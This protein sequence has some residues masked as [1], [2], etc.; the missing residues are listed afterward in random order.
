MASNEGEGAPDAQEGLMFHQ[1]MK[2]SFDP[3]A[4]P[5]AGQPDFTS[6]PNRPGL[7]SIELPEARHVHPLHGRA[8]LVRSLVSS[9]VRR[10][11]DA[12]GE[13][14]VLHGLGGCGKSSV[15]QDVARRALRDGV[16]V[17]WVNAAGPARISAC[18]REVTLRLGV[19]TRSIDDAWAGRGSAPDLLWRALNVRL[20]VWS[21]HGAQ[22]DLHQSSF[23]L[24]ERALPVGVRVMVHTALTALA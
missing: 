22:R 13:V 17:W 6:G 24:D 10:P 7:L 16:S 11:P 4:P 14:H 2:L 3:A 12:Y 19:A 23:D 8:A 18:L 1:K 20:G 21:G 9:I 15:A 5:P